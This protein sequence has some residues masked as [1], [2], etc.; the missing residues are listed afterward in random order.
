M[1]DTTT[2]YSKDEI[3]Q[4]IFGVD[5]IDEWWAMNSEFFIN[6]NDLRDKKMLLMGILSDVQ[7]MIE[8]GL[9]DD[10]RQTLNRAKWAI[11]TKL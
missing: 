2:H 1:N 5:C 3:N 6:Q 7:E 11:R 10:A 9:N 4:R 8:R